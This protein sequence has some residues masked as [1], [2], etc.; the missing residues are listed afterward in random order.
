MDYN[1]F[2]G[3]I[4][5]ISPSTPIHWIDKLSFI[6]I[7]VF[8]V[9]LVLFFGFIYY[10]FSSNDSFLKIPSTDGQVDNFFDAVYFSFVSATTTGFGDIVPEGGFKLIA[11]IEVVFGLLLLALVTSR[12]VSIKQNIILNEVYEISFSEKV[13]RLRSSLLLFRQSVD[14]LIVKVDE[15][16]VQKNNFKNIGNSFLNLEDTLSEIFVLFNKKNKNYFSKKVDNISTELIFN[17]IISSFERIDELLSLL[18]TKKL[19]FEKEKSFLTIKKCF[20]LVD[21]IFNNLNTLNLSQET[22]IEL[23]SRKEEIFSKLRAK[24]FN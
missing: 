9:I 18:E 21:P 16:N 6:H 12:L 13:T 4:K 17:S 8:W 7:L 3:L 23:N 11:I 20:L 2:G 19:H 5:R 14:R 22:I 10:S 1:K 15:Q 24:V